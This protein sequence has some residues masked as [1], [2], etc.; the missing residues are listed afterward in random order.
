VV[1]RVVLVVDD[2]SSH[3]RMLGDALE[4]AGYDTRRAA[5]GAAALAALAAAPPDLVLL[6][7]RMPGLDGM[8]VLRRIVARDDAPPVVMVTAHGD[9]R[10]AVE[11]MKVGAR[12]FLE[13]PVDIDE[14]RA[15]VADILERPVRDPGPDDADASA[16]EEPRS[17]VGVS[18]ALRRVRET[19]RLAAAS[20]ATVLVRGESGTGKELVARAIHDLSPRAGG[21]FVAVNCAAVAEGV[22]ES[23]LFGHERGAFTG[24]SARRRGRFEL[25]D[26]G[27]I[28]LDEIGEMRPH[29][30]AKL[31]RVLQDRSIER[32]GSS[33]PIKV[34]IRV[35]A[36]TNRDLEAEIGAGRFRE[37]LYYRLAVVEIVV[38]PLRD[39]REDVLPTAHHLLS[40]LADG[41][42]PRLA[43]DVSAALA[44]HDWP[45]NV[46]ELSNVLERAL[47][48]AP[49][50][51]LAPEHLPAHL[52]A[53]CR[54]EADSRPDPAPGETGVAAGLSLRAVER[55]LIEKT[56]ASFRGNRTHTAAALGLS[57]R[58]LLYKLKRYDIR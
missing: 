30:Q 47:L 19:V 24:A 6:D 43:A 42:A 5:D 17:I 39:R 18:E 35:V 4:A 53:L 52:C 8:A 54:A 40:R 56:L 48:F 21:P 41:P 49:R 11:A 22:L 37:D 1:R 36:A 25:A 55:E 38:P 7:V 46:R 12:D 32:V 33:A 50:G 51:D 44:L 13:K 26:G 20:S 2:E 57:R 3:R 9:V 28:F 10:L 34:D 16:A 23:E 58:A 27:T 31:L 29:L 14:L 45:G 15:V